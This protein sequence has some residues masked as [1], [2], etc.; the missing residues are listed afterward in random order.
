MFPAS[1]PV[2]RDAEAATDPKRQVELAKKALGQLAEEQELSVQDQARTR[3]YKRLVVR[4]R[5]VQNNGL[6]GTGRSLEALAD[7]ARRP[8]KCPT[9]PPHAQ[10]GCDSLNAALATAFPNVISTP[11]KIAQVDQSLVLDEALSE[12]DLSA[13]VKK[14]NGLQGSVVQRMRVTSSSPGLL[15]VGTQL[16]LRV[17]AKEKHGAGEVVW[18]AFEP[19]HVRQVGKI[20]DVGKAHVLFVETPR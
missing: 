15:K 11:G 5:I 17:G 9:A 3:A 1:W 4:M 7:V 14:T 19:R 13:F 18:V 20:W 2:L 6:V 12:G 16:Q 10:Q 8:F